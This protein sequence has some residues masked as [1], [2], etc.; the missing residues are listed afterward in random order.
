M[1]DLLYGFGPAASDGHDVLRTQLDADQER[2]LFSCYLN[3]LAAVYYPDLQFSRGK[4][5]RRRR[6]QQKRAAA[7]LRAGLKFPL[8]PP[9]PA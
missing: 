3:F 2:E 4:V 7:R 1:K 5:A 6:F 8:A 9:Y